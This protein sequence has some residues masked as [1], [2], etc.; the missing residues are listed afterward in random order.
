TAECII[1]A[2]ALENHVYYI[3]VNRVGVER[4]FEFIGD[5][6]ICDPSGRVLARACH[7]DE[8]ILY[9][10]VDS[11]RA[12]NKHVVRVAG[13]HEIDRFADRRPERYG[14]IAQTG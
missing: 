5:S 14:R 11:E 13:K 7:R 2:R 3:A 10:E 6:K 8:T 12:R 1:N 9:A 4:G